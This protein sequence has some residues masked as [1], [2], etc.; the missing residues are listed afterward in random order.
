MTAVVRKRIHEHPIPD[1]RTGRH[2]KHDPRSKDYSL[3]RILDDIFGDND[4]PEKD[5]LWKRMCP[6]FNQGDIGSCTGNAECGLLMTEPFFVQGRN[7]TEDDAVS[8]YSL[9]THIDPVD[10]ESY[11][12][13]DTGSSG[14]DI[15]KAAVE[16]QYIT[17]YHH[18]FSF[19]HTR[20]Y[21]GSVGP[22]IIGINWYDSFDTPNSSGVLSLPSSASVR[23]G[24]EIEIAGI[25]NEKQQIQAWQSWG[26]DWGDGGKM[27]FPF[28]VFEQLMDE[29][30][31]VTASVTATIK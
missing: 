30:G 6:P 18:S 3:K 26:E 2:V 19:L 17:S 28:S 29:D 31:D 13:D 23:G 24:H 14:L 15:C 9:A 4:I 11:P 22:L 5:A 25:D 8:L 1:K 16:K 20:Q 7:L 10:G 12:P 27:Y 21:L